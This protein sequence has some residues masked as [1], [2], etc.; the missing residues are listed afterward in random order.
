MHLHDASTVKNTFLTLGTYRQR[1]RRLWPKF[2]FKEAV[3]VA[4]A[5]RINGEFRC[6]V[7][8]SSRHVSLRSR[9]SDLACFAKVFLHEEYQSPFPT[10]PTVIVDAGANIGMATLY[11]SQTYPKAR[12]LS[13]EPEPSNFEM[14]TRNCGDLPNVTLVHGALW[15]EEKEL[16]LENPNAEKWAFSVVESQSAPRAESQKVAALTVPGILKRLGADHIDIFKMDVEGAELELFGNGADAWLGSVRQL[17][18]ELHDR[19]RPGCA[20]VFYT[21]VGRRPFLQE[22]RGESVFVKLDQPPSGS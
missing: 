3:R 19:F 10:E 8:H 2:G 16:V 7:P 13:I 12:I 1:V 15:F 14:L 6:R 5:E 17:V 9:T 22:T 11:Y 20:Q 18:I 4:L 21:A